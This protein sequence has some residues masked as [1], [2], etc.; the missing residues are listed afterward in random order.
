MYAYGFENGRGRPHVPPPLPRQI[1]RMR[2]LRSHADIRLPAI[3]EG[4]AV[5]AQWQM[6]NRSRLLIRCDFISVCPGQ[7]KL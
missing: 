5:A 4:D 2:L 7:D 1:C 3:G 6:K